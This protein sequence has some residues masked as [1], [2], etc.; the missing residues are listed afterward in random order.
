MTNEMPVF[1]LKGKDKL[2]LSTINYYLNKCISARLTEQA[3]EV[4]K[5]YMEMRNWQDDN[6]EEMKLP[7][8]KHIPV[9]E[10]H[11]ST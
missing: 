9:G 11:D 6:P 10:Q 2:A 8:H 3:K 1:I 7:D 4:A 5:A